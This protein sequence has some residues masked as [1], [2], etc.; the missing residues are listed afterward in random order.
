MSDLSATFLGFARDAEASALI[1]GE[2]LERI[3]IRTEADHGS[4]VQDEDM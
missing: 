2:D 4:L 1:L 3:H